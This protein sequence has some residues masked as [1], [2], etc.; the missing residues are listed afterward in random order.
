[1]TSKEFDKIIELLRIVF[2]LSR[3]R[4]DEKTATYLCIRLKKEWNYEEIKSGIEAAME[5]GEPITY[6]AIK[7]QIIGEIKKRKEIKRKIAEQK[8]RQEI[9][10]QMKIE[11][12]IP[13]TDIAKKLLKEINKNGK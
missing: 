13:Q 5:T 12:R 9:L 8:K 4:I 3:H 2:D 1:M 7:E 11:G 6:F 10:K